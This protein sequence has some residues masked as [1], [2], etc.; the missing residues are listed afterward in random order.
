MPEIGGRAETSLMIR[1]RVRKAMPM[2][3]WTP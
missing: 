3:F 2:T 1:P